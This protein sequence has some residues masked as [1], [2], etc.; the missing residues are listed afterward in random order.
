MTKAELAQAFSIGE[1]DKTFPYIADNAVWTI[2]EEN[3]FIGKSAIINN[4][5]L[6]SNYFKTV[7]TEF[8]TLNV[9]EDKNKVVVNGTAAFLIDKQCISFV[10]A[11]DIYEF[12]EQN[13]I[14]KIMSYCIESKN[15][16]KKLKR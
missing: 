11:C 16:N 3:T 9:I 14:E 12:D 4:C 6:V 2:V 7:E 1:F 13:F 5:E 15:E 10:S 8:K